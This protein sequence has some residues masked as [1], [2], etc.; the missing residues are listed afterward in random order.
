[1]KLLGILTD[2]TSYCI[3]LILGDVR[4]LFVCVRALRS[5]FVCVWTL[6]SHALPIFYL[7]VGPFLTHFC[8][9]FVIWENM[10]S[11]ICCLSFDISVF[12]CFGHTEFFKLSIT[13]QPLLYSFLTLT[14]RLYSLQVCRTVSHVPVRAFSVSKLNSSLEIT[15]LHISSDS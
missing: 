5:F 1:M 9:L 8:W 15:D 11:P 12:V 10:F 7:V 2:T 6:C 14:N 13:N 3:S 4:N